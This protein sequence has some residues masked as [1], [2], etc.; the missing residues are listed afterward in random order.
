MASRG[1]RCASL[2]GNVLPG[3]NLSLGLCRVARYGHSD[4]VCLTTPVGRR[5][6]GLTGVE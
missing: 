6:G 3:N 1:G 4:N 5:N 2:P